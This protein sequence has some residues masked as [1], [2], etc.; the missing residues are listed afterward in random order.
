LAEVITLELP[1]TLARRAKAEAIR[2]NR[3]LEAVLLEWLSRVE[4]AEAP[5]ETLPDDQ[6]LALSN[7]QLESQ[8]DEELSD[9]LARNREGQLDEA[10]R[11]RLDELM[12]SYRAGLVRKAQA[13]KV[14]VER[15]LRPP[16]N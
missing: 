14:A 6:V 10:A 3:P 15:G 4:A 12:H 11:R 7:A 8:Q 9:L 1:D 13:M 16:L 5:V 2:T